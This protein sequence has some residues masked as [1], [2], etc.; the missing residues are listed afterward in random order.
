MSGRL[1]SEV[2]DEGKYP[3]EDGRRWVCRLQGNDGLH[4]VQVE[5]LS[6]R[7]RTRMIEYFVRVLGKD[8]RLDRWVPESCIVDGT[9]VVP[10]APQQNGQKGLKRTRQ[11]SS[12]KGMDM[13]DPLQVFPMY[14]GTQID[15]AVI[16]HSETLRDVKWIEKVVFG[17]YIIDAW[18]P[19]PLSRTAIKEEVIANGGYLYVDDVTLKYTGNAGRMQEHKQQHGTGLFGL[20][21]PP[22]TCVYDY[23]QWALWELDGG[24]GAEYN[25]EVAENTVHEDITN[26]RTVEAAHR[27]LYCQNLGLL[28]KIFLDHKQECFTTSNFTYFVLTEKYQREDHSSTRKPFDSKTLRPAIGGTDYLFRGYFSREKGQRDYNLSCLMVLPPWQ[29]LGLGR[30]LIH[31]SYLL[32]GRENRPKRG[33]GAGSP[34]R[35][36]SDLGKMVYLQYWC[37]RVGMF[38]K[39]W[40]AKGARG[41]LSDI[42]ARTHIEKKD[43]L[44]ALCAMGVL[45]EPHKD[46]QLNNPDII[47][48]EFEPDGLP[49]PPKKGPVI[50]EERLYHVGMH[51]GGGDDDESYE[52]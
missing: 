8:R 29:R 50:N 11:V 47:F 39:E 22:G 2:T 26:H 33:V 38:L 44:K 12:K 24:E 5:L 52:C 6:K 31:F 17:D 48:W 34:E 36:L 51:F 49:V 14:D 23:G 41:T 13:E 10:E 42:I 37:E 28:S 18:Y 1:K 9:A 21:G 27:E 7:K 43:V 20:R 35:P 46:A 4:E 16:N 3:I 30:M 15:E 19:T 25:N 40:K 45:I 32:S